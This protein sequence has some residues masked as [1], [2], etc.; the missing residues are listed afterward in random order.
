MPGEA[1]DGLGDA[2][3]QERGGALDVLAEEHGRAL[4]VAVRRLFLL[5][6]LGEREL[7]LGHA[8][9]RV[10]VIAV[11]D[12][13]GH[14]V[15]I[16]LERQAARG[17]E[18]GLGRDLLDGSRPKPGEL[19]GDRLEVGGRIELRTQV[20]LEQAL[21]GLLIGRREVDDRVEAGLA[22]ERRVEAARILVGREDHEDLRS[23][24][25]DAV[26]GVEELAE[27][28]AR[29][30]VDLLLLAAVQ[31]GLIDVL[32][33]EDRAA[34]R[35]TVRSGQLVRG[36][37]LIGLLQVEERPAVLL[38]DLGGV[39]R[40]EGLARAGRP[41]E[42]RAAVRRDAELG[43]ELGAPDDVEDVR[44]QLLLQLAREDHAARIDGIEALHEARRVLQNVQLVALRRQ[45]D[46]ERVALVDA[47]LAGDAPRGLDDLADTRL[48]LPLHGARDEEEEPA[49]LE[50]VA[51]PE[52]TIHAHHADLVPDHLGRGGQARLD[53][54]RGHRARRRCPE[55][56]G[57]E[58]GHVGFLATIGPAE[59]LLERRLEGDSALEDE[60]VDA[61]ADGDGL[62]LL[63]GLALERVDELLVGRAGRGLDTNAVLED[64]Q[65]DGHRRDGVAAGIAGI[66][67]RVHLFVLVSF[68]V[69]LVVRVALGRRIFVVVVAVPT[70]VLFFVT[71][72]IFHM[73]GEGLEL[74]D[75]G[76]REG[77]EKLEVLDVVERQD[78]ERTGL[79]RDRAGRHLEIVLG[80]GPLPLCAASDNKQRVQHVRRHRPG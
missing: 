57:E 20:P 47:L 33:E 76:L 69:V 23:L 41:H 34:L 64:G 4:L 5:E 73:T 68:V 11:D 75:A 70:L 19:C 72:L 24:R 16:D 66:G 77:F 27:L 13:A 78:A 40:R 12:A 6:R 9:S 79:R 36:H 29:A 51:G 25:I 3:G 43:E 52:R 15:Q 65:A 14:V 55:Q 49:V 42:E 71:L 1:Q 56:R 8:E 30:L 67:L 50:F 7:L 35:V 26:E 80:D 37:D 10:E 62:L 53:G 61:L 54:D 17:A 21:G 22:G 44:L 18:D 32:H 58:A 59:L 2:V 46:L 38:G 74:F 60:S 48:V 45:I 39:R 28:L 63:L 31:D